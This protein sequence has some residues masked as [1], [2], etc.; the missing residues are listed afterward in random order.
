MQETLSR[1]RSRRRRQHA[2][3]LLAR[4]QL[5]TCAFEPARP[6]DL[7]QMPAT[8]QGRVVDTPA[9]DAAP[10]TVADSPNPP[11]ESSSDAPESS[12]GGEAAR[13]LPPTSERVEGCAFRL[14]AASLRSSAAWHRCRHR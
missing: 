12:V 14:A 2:A 7:R 11:D 6:D 13:I 5:S 1:P 4:A 3:R 10:R 9:P 8:C